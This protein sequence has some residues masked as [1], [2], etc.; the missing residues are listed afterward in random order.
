[1]SEQI[2]GRNAVLEAFRSGKCVDKLFILDGCQD[3]PVRTIAREAR[4]KDTIIN[5]VSKERL[6][7]LSETHA[8]QGVIAQV[9]AYE[10]ST[11]EDIL[12]KAEEKG[13]P[14]FLI[15]LDNVEDPHNLGAIIRTANLAG[16]HGV[17]IPKRRAVGLT[18]TVAKTSAGAINYT[19]VAKVT[20]LVRT[21]EEL[22]QKG[23]WF[24]CAD[25]GGESMYRMNLTGPI[26]LVIG[27]EGE[28]V[29]RL[30]RE[31]C[32]FTASIPMKGDIDS[33]NASVAAG[34]LAYEIV[35]QRLVAES[36]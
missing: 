4:K 15:L 7:Q 30:V 26:G 6:D 20:N 22:K 23:I 36:K 21:M 13:E 10:Y 2:E 11:V 29:S 24:V 32:D 35:R 5:Y 18:S 17:I 19:P 12:A 16:A 31:A 27:N 33:L 34:V 9:A 25:M 3:G 8:H 1:M 14:P 28:G